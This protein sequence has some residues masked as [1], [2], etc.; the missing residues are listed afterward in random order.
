[1]EP[2]DGRNLQI[3]IICWLNHHSCWANWGFIK[4]R[5]PQ[6]IQITMSFSIPIVIHDDWMI[7]RYH[8]L[9]KPM[10]TTKS[11]FLLVKSQ[12]VLLLLLGLETDSPETPHPT[13]SGRPG[14]SRPHSR[15]SQSWD[16]WEKLL[17][18]YIIRV[19]PKK[20]E[21]YKLSRHLRRKSI[22]FY[23]FWGLRTKWTFI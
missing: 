12:P 6:V 18:K 3:P 23:P 14:H 5:D 4:I 15:D 8:D 13:S 7:W 19:I 17:V 2:N 1:M 22:R 21:T 9:R 11:P 20:I 16:L 10:E